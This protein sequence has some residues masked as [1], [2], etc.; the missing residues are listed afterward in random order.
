[1]DRKREEGARTASE[2]VNANQDEDVPQQPRLR[3]RRPT[4]RRGA[5]PP[6]P[7]LPIGIALTRARETVV[8]IRKLVAAAAAWL[9]PWPPLPPCRSS[10][11][12]RHRVLLCSEFSCSCRGEAC[13]TWRWGSIY[14][15]CPRNVGRAPST[16]VPV[17]TQSHTLPVRDFLFTEE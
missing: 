3:R 9:V 5:L 1:M 8:G 16:I 12:L 6:S 2:L 10:G 11:S 4:G 13:L 14:M 7:A 17:F 15:D